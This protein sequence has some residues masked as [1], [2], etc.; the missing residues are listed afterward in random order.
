MVYQLG[1]E[2]ASIAVQFETARWIARRARD[3]EMAALASYLIVSTV[4]IAVAGEIL[5]VALMSSR[6]Q[7]SPVPEITAGSIAIE[8]VISVLALL[9]ALYG[10]AAAALR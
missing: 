8:N 2:I 6:A 9:T 10:C 4:A 5:S 1:G 3:R 7:G